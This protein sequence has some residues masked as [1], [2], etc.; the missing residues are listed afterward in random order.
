M[1]SKGAYPS[2]ATAARGAQAP[3]I[4][5][6]AAPASA[7][8]EQY[9]VLARR[10]E[11]R[12]AAGA[13]RIGVTSATAGEGRS[14][15]A[16]NLALALAARRRVILVEAHLRA[17][18][19]GRLFGAPSD[20]GVAAVL[21]GAA[22]LDEACVRVPG[23][24][25]LTLLP[26]GAATEP[27]LA[28]AAPRLAEV[29]GALAARFDAVVIDAPPVLPTADLLGLGGS[30]DAILF[31]V[32]ARRTSREL[33]LR[34]LDLLAGAP[35]LGFVLNGVDVAAAPAFALYARHDRELAARAAARTGDETG[36]VAAEAARG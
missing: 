36:L 9:R 2:T 10:V 20:A 3:Q 32:R 15:T 4:L 17:P 27:H 14:T 6:R 35:L 13:R 25:D 33:V 18:A 28:H 5:L 23:A 1:R 8:A 12:I 11:P 16:A 34:A 7:A 29:L 31:V 26:A 21:A 19:L 22:S 24:G 30:L